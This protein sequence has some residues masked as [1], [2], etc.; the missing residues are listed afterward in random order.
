MANVNTGAEKNLAQRQR[1]PYL[2]AVLF[3]LLITVAYP[4]LEP[5]L[6]SV[7]I[8][9]S[10]AV[11]GVWIVMRLRQGSPLHVPL[12]A[13]PF[14]GL[15]L[16]QAGLSPFTPIPST[17]MA[18]VL[19]GLVFLLVWLFVADS[20]RGR[21]LP[22]TWENALL[23]IALVFTMIELGIAAIWYARWAAIQG[24]L[25]PL[26]PQS[27]RISGL[28]IGHANVMAGFLN[29]VIPIALVRLLRS[30]DRTNRVLWG[31]GIVLFALTEYFASSRGGWISGVGAIGV[32]L[33]LC[34]LARFGRGFRALR[35]QLRKLGR[36]RVALIAITAVIVA[37]LFGLLLLRQS[38][39]APGHAPVSTARSS[40]WKPAWTIFLRSPIWGHGP[41]SF[42]V[43]FAQ[44]K[45][46]PP[47]F[48][49]SH[50]HNILL[51][52]CV[53]GGVLGLLLALLLASFVAW[54]FYSAWRRASVKARWDLAA[55]AGALTAFSLHHLVDFLLESPAYAAG[56]VII[57]CLASRHAPTHRLQRFETRSA[58]YAL[59]VLPVVYAIGSAYLGRGGVSYWQG[60]DA[61][62]AGRW[63]QAG[64]QICRAAEVNPDMP[65]YTF[66]CGLAQS[67]LSFTEHD[68]EAL[69]AAEAAIER[70][71]E[72]DPY[73]PVHRANLA[74]VKWELGRESQALQSM[75][76]AVISAPRNA[77][78]YLFL[79]WME[80]EHGDEAEALEAARLAL[81]RD[82]WL[83]RT[84]LF[85]QPLFQQA[86]PGDL[87]VPLSA[88]EQHAWAGWQAIDQG[89]FDQAREH[90]EGALA[91]GLGPSW[92]Y[93]GMAVVQARQGDHAAAERTFMKG[94][95]LH[96]ARPELLL[97]GS[98]IAALRGDLEG[99]EYLASEAL[100]S[101]MRNSDSQPYYSRTYL[102]YYLEPDT[103]PWMKSLLLLASLYQE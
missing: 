45:G 63:R 61:G 49:T 78:F 43:L 82:P 65:L 23:N 85:Q 31:I 58:W 55:Y 57:L 36:L 18:R 97:S 4:S 103:A 60:V 7:G 59:A 56:V 8:A 6:K 1:L 75:R 15:L 30:P 5:R 47:G 96:G 81:E 24:S 51:Q 27:Y 80:G 50:A 86:V 40:I 53:E 13:F 41:G 42:S 28:F 79:A 32:T 84:A 34:Y 72:S 99:S 14:L 95:F 66:Q 21:W 69:R 3:L 68:D 89:R 37:V 100:R 39:S 9:L 2:F 91:V 16:L 83:A 26:P 71:L 54:S 17:G 93:A 88:A 67:Y 52:I 25:F 92:A 87:A 64:E 73:W 102:R 19:S 35:E 29:L 33:M 12:A 48:A 44:E 10:L 98:R 11:F 62:R 90:F 76:E 22:A 74:G 46:L 20:L 70:G 101:V 38:Q 94:V 77:D